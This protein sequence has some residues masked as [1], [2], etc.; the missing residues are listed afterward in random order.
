VLVEH[1]GLRTAIDLRRDSATADAGA[2]WERLG[3]DWNQR[4]F[5][6]DRRPPDYSAG[7]RADIL[8]AY[9]R[10]LE[11]DRDSVARA[12]RALMT[13]ARQRALS[14]CA[15]VKDRTGALAALP[16]DLLRVPREVTAADYVLTR[17]NHARVID[18]PE[19][20]VRQFACQ[21][22]R[23]IEPARG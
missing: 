22:P 4:P 15:A 19:P 2:A 3:I 1:I 5:G 12:M 23:R 8:S 9:T 16:L 13:T 7:T 6:L 21:L 11:A 17:D 20:G 18:R 14:H 10:Y